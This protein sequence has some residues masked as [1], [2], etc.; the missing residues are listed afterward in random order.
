MAKTIQNK[1][2]ATDAFLE[3]KARIDLALAQLKTASDD[4]FDTNP[5]SLNWAD[6]GSIKHIA[7]LLERA[8]DFMTGEN[9]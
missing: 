5:D 7:D 9:K 1:R 3:H 8:T 6:V 2:T 4:H